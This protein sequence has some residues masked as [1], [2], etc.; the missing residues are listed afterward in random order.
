[1]FSVVY[2]SDFEARTSLHSA[3][4]HHIIP[5]LKVCGRNISKA[6]SLFLTKIAMISKAKKDIQQGSPCI[7]MS[8]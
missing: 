7:T 5:N 8:K 3:G 2:R 6:H 4:K 1:M